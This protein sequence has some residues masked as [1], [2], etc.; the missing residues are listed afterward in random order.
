MTAGPAGEEWVELT[1]GALPVDAV[2]AWV[3]RPDC[4]AV[5][6]FVGTV[7]DHAEGRHGV[8][9]VEYEAY[10]ERVAPRLRDI[11]GSARRHHP[12]IGRVA[13]LH[14]IGRLAVGEAS[15]V[16]AVSSAHRAAAFDAARYCIDTVKTAVPIWKKESWRDGEDWVTGATPLRDVVGSPRPTEADRR[17]DRRDGSAGGHPSGG[18]GPVDREATPH[19]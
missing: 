10:V 11:V 14:R 5:V 12:E 9:A 1:T 19:L 4:G 2:Q 18:L 13:L 8:Y 3:V 7:R 6:V 16:V 15:V 17:P